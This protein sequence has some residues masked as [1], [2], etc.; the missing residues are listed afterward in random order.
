MLIVDKTDSFRERQQRPCAGQQTLKER[1]LPV[2]K[3]ANESGSAHQ[4]VNQRTPAAPNVGN[5]GNGGTSSR[6][7]SSAATTLRTLKQRVTG[8]CLVVGTAVIDAYHTARELVIEAHSVGVDGPA[9]WEV[10]PVGGSKLQLCGK[11]N[12]AVDL[13]AVAGRLQA[14]EA[15]GGGA[16]NSLRELSRLCDSFAWPLK[17]RMVDTGITSDKLCEELNRLRAEYYPLGL[18]PIGRNLVLGSDIGGRTGRV[19]LRGPV[20]ATASL[21]GDWHR[22]AVGVDS[23]LELVII[24]SPKSDDVAKAAVMTARRSG[25][26]LVAVLTSS[27]SLD[28][29]LRDLLAKSDA[30]VANLGEF[31]ELVAPLR[32]DCPERE[33]FTSVPGVAE[34]MS[35]LIE[36]VACG[37]LAI[38]MGEVGI[39]LFDSQKGAIVHIGLT[40]EA[41]ALCRN[42]LPAARIN[43]IGDAYVANLAVAMMFLPQVGPESSRGI[44]AT[45]RAW[46]ELL[47]GFN[48]KFLHP[49][50]RWFTVRILSRRAPTKSRRAF[51][52]M[53]SWAEQA[54]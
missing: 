1:K 3:Q 51:A 8:S 13:T 42:Y 4:K 30:A 33:H 6:S 16:I 38:T 18:G 20:P 52:E 49:T 31:R 50:D 23:K 22:I 21:N 28:C 17:L 29:R 19:V 26:F 36:I 24:N 47:A 46:M 12:A 27:T 11:A 44:H 45:R 48:P 35:E 54:L 25:A 9:G 34:A 53:W 14:R 40:D 41:R 7:D 5:N 32:I 15:N 2:K 37:D 43:G 39:V 10:I